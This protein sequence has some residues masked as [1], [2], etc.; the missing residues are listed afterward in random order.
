VNPDYFY[1][2]K[3]LL[4]FAAALVLLGCSTSGIQI[5]QEQ[6][7]GFKKGE[8]HYQEVIAQAGVPD[9]VTVLPDGGRE[10]TYIYT[11]IQPRAISL[12]PYIGSFVEGRDKKVSTVTFK[13]TKRAILEDYSLKEKTTVIESAPEPKWEETKRSY[14]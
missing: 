4:I 2:M 1:S 9:E 12:I 13:F 6:L 7:K 5:T 11:R 14:F 8:T 3:K 10:I